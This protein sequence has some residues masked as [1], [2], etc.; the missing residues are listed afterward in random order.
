[1]YSFI[2]F[3]FIH[4]SE[5]VYHLYNIFLV[6]LLNCVSLEFGFLI[7]LSFSIFGYCLVSCSF[8]FKHQYSIES[9]AESPAE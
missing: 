1:M 5:S 9:V 7:L 4:Y 3:N 8:G 6:L 2:V